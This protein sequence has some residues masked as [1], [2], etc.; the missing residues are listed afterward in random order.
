MKCYR[1]IF[2]GLVVATAMITGIR[3]DC[4]W[5]PDEPRVAEIARET[6]VGGHWITPYLCGLPFLEKSS[7]YYNL[8]ALA[9]KLTGR[10]TSEINRPDEL[11]KILGSQ[12]K[13][14]VIIEPRIFEPSS[15]DPALAGL[16]QS[17]RIQHITRPDPSPRLLLVS[18][19]D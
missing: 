18:N 7:L 10:T 14:Y 16:F 3:H 12:E 15:R 6:L 9:F 8:I 17:M 2:V 5:S 4:L 11:K 13:V 19:H 1:S